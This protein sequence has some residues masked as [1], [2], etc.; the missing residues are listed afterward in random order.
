M[1][2]SVQGDQRKGRVDTWYKQEMSIREEASTQAK[3]EGICD[4]PGRVSEYSRS[5]IQTPRPVLWSSYKQGQRETHPLRK[6]VKSHVI[7]TAGRRQYQTI[8]VVI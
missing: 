8:V 7:K 2:Y 1:T 5:F 4:Q 6:L 3:Q